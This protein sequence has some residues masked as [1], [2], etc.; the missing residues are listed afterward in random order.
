MPD[1]IRA[2]ILSFEVF[3]PDLAVLTYTARGATC[4]LAIGPCQV[5]FLDTVAPR[6]RHA[7]AA[8]RLKRAEAIDPDLVPLPAAPDPL[9]AD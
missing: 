6:I 1:F 8:G 3:S 2:E 7:M 4:R 5:E 9:P